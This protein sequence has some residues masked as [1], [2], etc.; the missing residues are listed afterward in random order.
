M[1]VPH[2]EQD[3]RIFVTDTSVSLAIKNQILETRIFEVIASMY[4]TSVIT[5][6]SRIK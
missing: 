1:W 5:P 6:M 2:I 3:G 4:D